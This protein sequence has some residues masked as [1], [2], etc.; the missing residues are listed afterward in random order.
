MKKAARRRLCYQLITGLVL[1]SLMASV[2][3]ISQ[4][5]T[6]QASQSHIKWCSG[7]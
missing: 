4:E 1:Y 3:V 5:K 6:T 2:S 7:A